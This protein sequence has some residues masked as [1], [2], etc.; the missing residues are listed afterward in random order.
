[1]T[2]TTTQLMRCGNSHPRTYPL[3]AGATLLDV[4]ANLWVQVDGVDVRCPIGGCKRD[5]IGARAMRVAVIAV[6]HSDGPCGDK[7]LEAEGATC[8]CSCGGRNHGAE[9]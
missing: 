8:K 3:P 6:T 9:A 1:M 4:N 5:G 2:Q 7:C